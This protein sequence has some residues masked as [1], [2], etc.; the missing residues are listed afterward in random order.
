MFGKR[1][2]LWD[3]ESFD[4]PDYENSDIPL[5]YLSSLD[6]INLHT[7][8]E[9]STDS[10]PN[11]HKIYNYGFF[12]YKINIFAGLGILLLSSFIFMDVV[13]LFIPFKVG[14]MWNGRKSKKFRY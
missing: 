9:K 14:E 4:S 10:G 8:I 7:L 6:N 5:G 12:N 1:G 11:E 13:F 3:K 2:G